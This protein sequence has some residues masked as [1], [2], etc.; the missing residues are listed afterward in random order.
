M[1]RSLCKKA[2]ERET[3]QKSYDLPPLHTPPKFLSGRRERRDQDIFKTL[4]LADS[5]LLA[6][7]GRAVPS[8]ST[9]EDASGDAA[10]VTSPPYT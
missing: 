8:L 1:E 10:Q 2:C 4:R 7:H 5:S 6:Y 3:E 9:N